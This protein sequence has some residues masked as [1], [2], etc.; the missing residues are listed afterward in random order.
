M[1]TAAIPTESA[2]PS[3]GDEAAAEIR[4]VMARRRMS[5]R[6]LA[7][8][9]GREQSWV[10]RRLSGAT[11]MTTNDLDEIT[12]VLGMTTVQLVLSMPSGRRAAQESIT[13]R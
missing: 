6:D 9:L 12:A 10:S 8:G 4:A 5:G 2:E 1:T 11:P 13:A 3:F 7:R